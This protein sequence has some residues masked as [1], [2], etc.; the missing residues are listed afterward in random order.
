MV[1][2]SGHGACSQELDFCVKSTFGCSYCVGLQPAYSHWAGAK[3]T[4]LK[5]RAGSVAKWDHSP[6]YLL[7]KILE[8]ATCGAVVRSI[9][10]QLHFPHLFGHDYRDGCPHPE[11]YWVHKE[12]AACVMSSTTFL[13]VVIY[14]HVWG[15]S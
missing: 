9:T 15:D 12:D 10:S 5:H 6:D 11:G 1:A 7:L 14:G 13:Q 3:Q 4:D 2:E 8:V